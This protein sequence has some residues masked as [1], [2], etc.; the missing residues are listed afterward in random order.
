MMEV[1]GYFFCGGPLMLI[2]G[3]TVNGNFERY[4]SPSSPWEADPFAMQHYLPRS[5]TQ[6]SFWRATCKCLTTK[7]LLHTCFQKKGSLNTF[8]G[9]VCV[10]KFSIHFTQLPFF[11]PNTLMSSLQIG[12]FC[13]PSRHHQGR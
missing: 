3:T 4:S 7:M 1:T 9:F 11:S 6:R 12:R 10:G 2:M 13:D 5:H 8:C